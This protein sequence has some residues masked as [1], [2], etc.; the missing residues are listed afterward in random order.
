MQ[1]LDLF[2]FAQRVS[3][4]LFPLFQ[5]T[6]V[7]MTCVSEVINIESTLATVLHHGNED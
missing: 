5:L 6:P 1:L 4:Q 2:Q 7:L 3:K